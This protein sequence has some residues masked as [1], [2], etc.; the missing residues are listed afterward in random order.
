MGGIISS[1]GDALSDAWRTLQEITYDAWSILRS[2]FGDVL[3]ILLLILLLPFLCYT[4]ITGVMLTAGAVAIS[5]PV[6]AMAVL[7]DPET[8][9]VLRDWATST[10]SDV[11]VY[12]GETIA[13]V[14][15]RVLSRT[16]LTTILV[17]GVILYVIA[18]SGDNER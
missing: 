10:I 14:V 6:M 15:G 5:M 1:I 9:L 17:G 3:A 2:T 16:G 13:E 8:W 7:V 12:T 4:A 18:N 11:L